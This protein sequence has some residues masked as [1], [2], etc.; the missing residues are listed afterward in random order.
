VSQKRIATFGEHGKSVRVFKNGPR[1][2]VKSAA[3]GIT[4]SYRGAGA[5]E[6]ALGFARRLAEGRTGTSPDT[7][8]VGGLWERY[9]ASSDF[10]TLRPRTRELYLE[11]WRY[12]TSVVPEY[13]L[14]DEVIPPTLDTA[15][16]ALQS[17]KRPRAP[18]GLA[19]SSVQHIV[20]TVKVVWAWGERN[21][22]LGRNRIY[23]YRFKV[24][25][26]ARQGSPAEYTAEEYRKIL[27]ALSFD[28][29]DQRRAYVALT[30]IGHQGTRGSAALKLRWEDVDW[31]ADELH[32]RPEWDKMGKD[33]RQPMRSAT[34]AVLGRLWDAAGQPATG[35]VFP[36]GN[37]LA[38]GETYT[39]VG[40]L[41]V[42]RTAEARAGVAHLTGRGGHGLRRM[43][44]GDLFDLTGSA[45]AAMEGIG[46]S[47]GQAVKYV[48]TRK[49][50]TAK[51]LRA[52]DGKGV[53]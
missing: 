13:T 29:L 3:L 35:W 21:Q 38:K 6:K 18:E 1:V 14:A 10:Q 50:R 5:K 23:A 42:L 27:G 2:T 53:A 15:R 17:T 28:R 47:I 34:R 31:T 43:V 33:W 16:Q 36:A 30:L 39:L 48:K 32:W 25:R 41:K 19:L 20:R 22:I 46:D 12:F 40:L 52:L 45:E 9:A 8:T 24:S 51:T 7:V 11:H 26:D 49:S 37:S 4:K 44:A